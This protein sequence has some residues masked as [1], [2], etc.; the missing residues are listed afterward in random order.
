MGRKL[1]NF[2]TDI[3]ENYPELE[4]KIST[5]MM[6]RELEEMEKRKSWE[7]SF[8][9]PFL[10]DLACIDQFVSQ[11]FSYKGAMNCDG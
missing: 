8:S 2:L 1:Q 7:Q 3:A 5:M 6:T 11:F 9:K 4:V 10:A